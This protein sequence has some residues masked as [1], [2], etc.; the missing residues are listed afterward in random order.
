MMKIAIFTKILLLS[1]T[2][3]ANEIQCK[4]DG[5]QIE[6]NRCAYE[7]FKKSDKMLNKAYKKLREKHKNDKNYL[8][9]LKNSQLLWIKF[10]DAELELIFTCEDE[11]KRICFGSMYPL[12]YNSEKETIT[13]ARTKVLQRYLRE[14]NL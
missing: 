12:L 10:R 4:E 8:T 14:G 3:Y 5:T 7:V 11:N 6:M 2:L 1:T 13:K 9:N